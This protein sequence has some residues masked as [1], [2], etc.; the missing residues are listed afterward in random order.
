MMSIFAY[1]STRIMSRIDLSN[2]LFNC[3]FLFF[4]FSN[5]PTVTP[6]L[7][8]IL[9]FNFKTCSVL[10]LQILN[11]FPTCPFIPVSPSILNLRMGLCLNSVSWEL[12]RKQKLQLKICSPSKRKQRKSFYLEFGLV[13][14]SKSKR[15][16]LYF[17]FI[18]F[19]PEINYEEFMKQWYQSLGKKKPCQVN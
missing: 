17:Y 14:T 16:E 2:Q 15:T 5:L 6:D 19:F 4:S 11:N 3:F 10:R 9:S 1:W 8:F 7:P 12:T 18:L 13:Y